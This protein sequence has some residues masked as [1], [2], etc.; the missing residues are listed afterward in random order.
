MPRMPK[1]MLEIWNGLPDGP[2]TC[3]DCGR[4]GEKAY[5]QPQLPRRRGEPVRP[6]LCG[7]CIGER[8]RQAR[9]GRAAG[10]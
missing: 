9:Q 8:N 3:A 7:D 4:S 1:W 10:R 2:Y 6:A 5:V